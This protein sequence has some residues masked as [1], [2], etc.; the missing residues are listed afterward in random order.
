MTSVI[1]LSSSPART[2]A[3]SQTPVHFSSDL[4]SPGAL[5]TQETSPH[6]QFKSASSTR[7]SFRSSFRT[8]RQVLGLKSSAEN[9]PIVSPTKSKPKIV[10]RTSPSLETRQ[11]DVTPKFVPPK[12]SQHVPQSPEPVEHEP[13][14]VVVKITASDLRKNRKVNPNLGIKKAAPRRSDWTPPR[15]ASEWIENTQ[16]RAVASFGGK[17]LE[18]FGNAENTSFESARASDG[19]LSKGRKIDLETTA[20]ALKPTTSNASTTKKRAKS[21]PKKNL[22]ITALATSAYQVD[23]QPEPSPMLSYLVSTQAR[24]SEEVE[25]KV[26]KRLRTAKKQPPKSRLKSPTTVQKT[27]DSQ[28]LIFA[29]ASQLARDES[30]T[31][32]KDTLEAMKQAQ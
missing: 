17:L 21:P 22:T 16:E 12:P 11:Q 32:I 26:K 23:A 10:T 28:E 7:D 8:A 1:L 31:L 20:P 27:L 15:F 4:P 5:L 30:P 13:E 18:S 6:K 24:G 29:S 9:V 3:R 25:T 14:A 19:S 2:F